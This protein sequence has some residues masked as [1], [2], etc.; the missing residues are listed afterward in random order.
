MKIVNKERNETM[1]DWNLE[2]YEEPRSSQFRVIS[3]EMTETK[4]ATSEI[5]DPK[6]PPPVI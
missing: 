2:T 6:L 4:P 3:T 1:K 5:I